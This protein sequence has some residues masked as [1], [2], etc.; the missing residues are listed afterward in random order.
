M[1]ATGTIVGRL[2]SDPKVIEGKSDFITFSVAVNRY[3]F[4]EGERVADFYDVICF[5][6]VDNHLKNIH[7]GTVVSVAGEI[8]IKTYENRDGEEKT[9]VEIQA[10]QL[11]YI[12][13]YGEGSQDGDYDDYDDSYDD[14]DDDLDDLD[15]DDIDDDDDDFFGENDPF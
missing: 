3:D 13:N 15:F 14:L 10:N 1:H 4:R 7:K 11:N 5:S 2:T 12:D 8:R 9:Q 6:N